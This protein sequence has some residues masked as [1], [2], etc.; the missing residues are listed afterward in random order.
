MLELMSWGPVPRSTPHR[1]SNDESSSIAE[2]YGVYE[3]A[4]LC[5]FWW[6]PVD[7]RSNLIQVLEHV[8]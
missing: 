5:F 3:P 1:V 7:A 8:L 2:L 4:Q 6:P